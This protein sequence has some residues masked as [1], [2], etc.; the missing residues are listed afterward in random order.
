MSHRL[1]LARAHVASVVL[2]TAVVGTLLCLL[3]ISASHSEAVHHTKR[4]T[5]RKL[6]GAFAESAGLDQARTL[7]FEVCNGFAN[8]RLALVYGILLAHLLGRAAVLPSVL[9]N[10]TQASDEWVAGDA[11][12][13]SPLSNMYDSQVRGCSLQC[14][15]V[16]NP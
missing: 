9:T 10:G 15:S 6:A 5:A 12:S 14:G 16:K 3:L 13:T 1:R 7:R 11:N 8:Q 2:L 4:K